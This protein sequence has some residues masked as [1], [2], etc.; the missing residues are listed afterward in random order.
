MRPSLLAA[1]A[2]KLPSWSNLSP[3]VLRIGITDDCSIINILLS[4]AMARGVMKKWTH[5]ERLC[6]LSIQLQHLRRAEWLQHSEENYS[7][8]VKTP[9]VA[10]RLQGD[11]GRRMGSL[12]SSLRDGI[13]SPQGEQVMS[14]VGL[15]GWDA[16]GQQP[17]T[18]CS[19]DRWRARASHVISAMQSMGAATA[20]TSI[21]VASTNSTPNPWYLITMTGRQFRCYGPSSSF[22]LVFPTV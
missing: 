5:K 1:S 20:W 16:T 22:L 18:G 4:K 3:L 10:E 12:Y 14:H 19:C 11:L 21:S 8:M 2:P 15:I 6:D 7:A 9:R 17:G 13:L